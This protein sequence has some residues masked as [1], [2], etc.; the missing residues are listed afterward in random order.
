[1]GDSDSG[2]IPPGLV[3]ALLG[4]AGILPL[5]PI[6][7]GIACRLGPAPRLPG[8]EM[9]AG[10]IKIATFAEA[11][12]LLLAAP[13]AAFFFGKALP[14]HL[15][16]RCAAG[17]LSFEWI[18]AG[19]AISFPLWRGGDRA[20][21]AM[22]AAALLAI[23]VG[24]VILRFHRRLRFR[25]LF[26]RSR[27]G[28]LAWVFLTGASWD[29]ARLASPRHAPTLL[30]D[31]L[32]EMALAGLALLGVVLAAGGVAAPELMRRIARRAWAPLLLSA[33]AILAGRWRPALLLLAVASVAVSCAF[34]ARRAQSGCIRRNSRTFGLLA[35]LLA[36]AATIY[37]RPAGEVDLFEDGH[38]LGLAETY[39][40][41][42]A[43]YVDTYPLHGWGV[44]GGVD[45]LAFR[46]A[47]PSLGTFRVRR[48]AVT[49]VA[50][51][52]L[53]AFSLAML[54]TSAGGALA[55]LV[56]LSLCPFLSERHALAFV[57]LAFL[58]LGARRAKPWLWAAGGALAGWEVLFSLD[59][60]VF[61][62][63]GA[64]LGI[65]TLPFLE[66]GP[67]R[68][69]RG[70]R[71]GL[72]F[73]GG[74]LGAAAPFL[75]DL[76]WKG[77]LGAFA[78][79]SFRE[80]P[81]FIGDV[82]GLPAG[83]VAASLRASHSFRDCLLILTGGRSG[84]PWVFLMILLAIAGAV[85]LWRISDRAIEGVD[86]AVW[87]GFAFMVVSLRGALGRFDEGHLA[88]YSVYSGPIAAWLLV[89]AARASRHRIVLLLLTGAFLLARVHP[90]G[91]IRAEVS[92]VALS[93][94]DRA[95][96]AKRAAALR[97]GDPGEV[98][99][100]QAQAILAIKRFVDGR[101]KPRE[102][103]FDFSN[104]P[105][106]Y[107]LLDRPMPTRYF[108]VPLYESSERQREVI[109]ALEIQRPPLA[110]LSGNTF[111]DAFDGVSNARRAP[112]VAAYLRAHYRP[113]ALVAG[114]TL[115]ERTA[116]SPDREVSSG[117]P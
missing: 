84:P 92:A 80:I 48:A 82:W 108:A 44:D 103:F 21:T 43:P 75:L 68:W 101:L 46:F 78:R 104:E 41:G 11:A 100:G 107:F 74:T 60:G 55:L 27:R 81:S 114:R 79:A 69:I 86:R 66:D 111:G 1:M 34:P 63:G 24:F 97:S 113:I 45:S 61:L 106:L 18:A 50:A 25:R 112:A 54:G 90:I 35:Y 62:C 117:R 15:E 57:S 38:S 71:G 51:A 16:S 64:L 73:L 37:Y 115:A 116:S 26:V 31:P 94:G 96:L 56:S 14:R 12:T 88:L 65:V 28:D 72:W 17:K 52:G 8:C 39:L 22:A 83:S 13:L 36:C 76:A 59:L 70:L 77:S 4:G 40:H 87:I 49:V 2:A 110:I 32:S 7:R 20:G 58:A 6:A 47:G 19:F 42:G 105:A 85:F 91:T 10:D 102:T 9:S 30:T 93:A 95:E 33:G 53:G 23:L 89:R 109:D 3:G 29:L 5:L 99:T 98:P 67:G